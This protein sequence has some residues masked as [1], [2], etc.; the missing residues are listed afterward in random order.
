MDFNFWW[1]WPPPPK[2]SVP[3]Q[4]PNHLPPTPNRLRPIWSS[5]AV[6]QIIWEI[7]NIP[8][9]RYLGWLFRFVPVWW[10]KLKTKILKRISFVKLKT[11]WIF[12]WYKIEGEF[13]GMGWGVYLMGRTGRDGLD[14]LDGPQKCLLIFFILRYIKQYTHIYICIYKKIVPTNFLW[15]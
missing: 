12:W 13:D 9:Q 3:T 15:V 4:P 5:V 14:G 6:A 11:I 2:S 8:W 10:L 7:P 1:S